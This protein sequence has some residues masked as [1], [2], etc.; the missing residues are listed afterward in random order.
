MAK[1]GY[2]AMIIILTVVLTLIIILAGVFIAR[3]Y[4][5]FQSISTLNKVSNY[6]DFNIYKMNIKYNYSID[7]IIEKGITDDQS[8]VNAI[9]SESLP[10]LPININAP[11]FACSAFTMRA[12]N[13]NI[14]MGR[15]YDF[16][17][18]SSALLVYCNPKN[19]YKSVAT[20]ALDNIKANVADESIKTKL[21]CLI[22]PFVC[23][24]GMN[25]KGVSIAVLT[26]DS[27]PTRQST[28]KPTIG[29]T[30]AIR[31]VLDRAAST[32]E[33]VDLLSKYDMFATSGRD[34]HFYI[35]DASGDGRVVEYDC[36]NPKRPLIAT[37]IR[38]ITNFY[39]MY[40][41]K[42]LPNQKNG[43]YGHGKER[44]DKIEK[45]FESESGN[46]TTES[47]W[48]ALKS[49]SQLPNPMDITSN[50]QWSIVYNDTDLTAKIVLRRNWK[51]AYSYSINY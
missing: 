33:A 46:Y 2:A 14:L 41:D 18:D 29:T 37:P 44:Y 36:D 26:L 22:A 43:V 28:G 23:L 45:V 12:K 11:K 10:F 5:R 4:S 25:E 19:G 49:A 42:V 27:K 47:A 6:A 30:L 13:G 7:K 40:I 1:G 38:T 35:T 8:F 48:N 20:A 3:Y 21:T 39:G 34:Y 9:A 32:Q 50:T 31:L 51:D 15:N 17:N 24:D 16:K